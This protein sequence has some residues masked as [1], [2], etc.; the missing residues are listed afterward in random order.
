MNWQN[1]ELQ[2]KNIR[3]QITQ[4]H[5]DLPGAWVC[6]VREL[7]WSCKHLG[8]PNSAT[9]E[10]AQEVA[11]LIVRDHLRKMLAELS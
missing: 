2:T 6:H 4:R 11:V 1:N 10:E 5:V 9:D 3:I 8:I 7:G